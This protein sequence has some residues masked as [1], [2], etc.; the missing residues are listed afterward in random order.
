MAQNNDIKKESKSF[1]PSPFQASIFDFIENKKESLIIKAVAG[2]GKTTTIVDALK[3]IP[4]SESI[5]FLSFNK[6]IAQE[7]SKRVPAHVDVSTFNSLGDK[8]LR[9][10]GCA[11][12]PDKVSKVVKDK[13]LN[14]GLYP[15]E[16]VSLVGLAK[17]HMIAA[18]V[19]SLAECLPDK[20]EIWED[21]YDSRTSSFADKEK[22]EEVIEKARLLLANLNKDR[23]TYDFDDQL[24]WTV[25]FE[26]KV[27]QYKVIFVD[28]AQDLSP[29]QIAL[30]K[31]LLLPGGRV[32]AVGDKKQAIY[33]F[34]GS[35]HRSL[36]KIKDAFRCHELPLSVSYRCAKSIVR[37]AQE[38]NDQIEPHAGAPEGEVITIDEMPP[39]NDLKIPDA[40]MIARTNIE[41]L[42]AAIHLL[43]KGIGFKFLGFNLGD[44]VNVFLGLA[45]KLETEHRQYSLGEILEL[46]KLTMLE[47]SKDGAVE[48]VEDVYQIL[49]FVAELNGLKRV[50]DLRQSFK[51]LIDR[52]KTQKSGIVL[53]TIHKSKGLEFDIV[54]FL[55]SN[56]LPLSFVKNPEVLAQEY[57]LIYVAIT[58]AKNKLVHV[59]T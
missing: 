26:V 44:E 6:S 37:N 25:L 33:G 50:Y 51:A 24:Y 12:D 41:L 16:V 18:G 8:A 45:S 42:K 21:L 59:H 30:L 35:D 40:A 17:N 31:R 22:K 47:N 55:G 49:D 11:L 36:D 28:E 38:F 32:V 2:S 58:R 3:R 52:I 9:A 5:L 27:K 56:K 29:V 1:N 7:L 53:S 13:K 39:D 20:K 46:T 4:A 23:K 48:R 54:Y 14:L 19:I 34:R 10:I 15:K 43:R 57:N